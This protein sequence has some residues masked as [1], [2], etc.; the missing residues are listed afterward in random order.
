MD[1]FNLKQH[2]DSVY[3]YYPEGRRKPVIGITANVVDG[4]ASLRN[5]Y[6]EQV[7]NAGGVPM[8]IPSV[9]DT[10][11][12]VNILD[13]IDG[14]LLSGGGDY[15]PLW[16][17][18]EPSEKLGDVNPQRDLAEL[19]ITRLAYN[20]Q[21]PMLGICRGCQTLAMALDG[22]VAQDLSERKGEGETMIK[23]SQN[24]PQYEP[25]H[26]VT[27]LSGTML[28]EIYNN[29]EK[30]AVNSFHHQA[31]DDAGK[32]FRISAMA[33]DGV[34]EAIESSELHTILGVQWHPEW[35]GEQG[36]PLFEWLVDEARLFMKAKDV[37]ADILTLDTHCDTPMLFPQGIDFAVRDG[38]ILVDMHKLDDGR[39]DAVTM[40]AYIPQDYDKSAFD[41]ADG[42]FNKLEDII[43]KNRLYVVKASNAAELYANK[44]EGKHSIMF[45]I[46]NGK[47]LE[48][49]ISKVKYFADRGVVYI[50]L[51]HNGDNDLCDSARGTQTWGGL[52][53]FGKDVV[54]EM[55][56]CGVLVDLSHA[57]E[58]TFY[59][60]LELSSV[61]IVC[62]HS[63]CR[64][65][66]DHPRNLTDE[67]MKAM[68][69]KGGVCQ[70]TLY[71]GF[72][73]NDGKASMS[74][75]IAHLEHAIDVMGIDHVGIGT[76]YDGDGGVPGMADTSENIRLTV[77]LLRR[78]YSKEDIAKIWGGN[79]LRVLAMAKG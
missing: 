28:S 10:D 33:S 21:I 8:I 51:C 30:I 26:T 15:N 19:K 22:H 7:V 54:R 6:Y 35:L 59:D 62:S 29:V 17:G 56:R 36:L 23:H 9:S 27:I 61:P 39:Q 64:A 18:E 79:W 32:R 78:G 44:R 73:R 4:S 2:L 66:C 42:I 37:H 38:R 52:S 69:R 70:I 77:E 14:L 75:V 60:A 50:T 65:L 34:I 55:N 76:D 24:A 40:A 20:R 12:I 53:K 41:Y 45:A 25:T 1:S 16:V 58:T 5:H 43:E 47:A 67:Q 71:N 49:D 72:L 63:S 46:E 31:V 3:R 48:G 68:A 74:D 57:A 13:R 11:T